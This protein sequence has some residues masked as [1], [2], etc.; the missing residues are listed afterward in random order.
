MTPQ[1][2]AKIPFLSRAT[3]AVRARILCVFLMGSVDC[4]FDV[5]KIVQL[6]VD[7]A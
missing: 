5:H 3:S 2:K 6:T 7:F 1:A 4:F